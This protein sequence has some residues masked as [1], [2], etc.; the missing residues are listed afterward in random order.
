[1]T[2]PQVLDRDGSVLEVGSRV[3]RVLPNSDRGGVQ[4]IVTWA[5][6]Q[7]DVT[8]ASKGGAGLSTYPAPRA[9]LLSRTRRCPDLTLTK[10]KEK[11]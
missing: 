2:A 3:E 11:N 4:G 10:A 8:W 5:K 1:M 9:S 6:R 7:V